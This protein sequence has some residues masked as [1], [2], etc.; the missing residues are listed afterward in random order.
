MATTTMHKMNSSTLKQTTTAI[1]EINC[2]DAHNWTRLQQPD[3]RW[4]WHNNKTNKSRYN[5]P[6][7]PGDIPLKT[8][9]MFLKDLQRRVIALESQ[10]K[11][12]TGTAVVYDDRYDNKA[13]HH[14]EFDNPFKTPPI[15]LLTTSDNNY[16]VAWTNNVT[17]TGFNF[18]LDV[19]HTLNTMVP[20]SS[21]SVHWVAFPHEPIKKKTYTSLSM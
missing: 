15:V 12:S 4:Y 18:A 11:Y 7:L 20:S 1:A 19:H 6:T 3:G 8:Q 5:I 10:K 16:F 13:R 2:S 17:Q 9:N 14:V 21:A